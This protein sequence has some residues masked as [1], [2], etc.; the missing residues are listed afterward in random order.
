MYSHQRHHYHQQQ[1]N[2]YGGSGLAAFAHRRSPVPPALS[3]NEGG[4]SERRMVMVP[5]QRSRSLL[6]TLTSNSSDLA[7]PLKGF[8][9]TSPRS[10]VFGSPT[11]K[12]TKSFSSPCALTIPK[13]TQPA[14]PATA[15]PTA[16]PKW[17]CPNKEC[18][19]TDI[20]LVSPND[21]GGTSCDMCGV[22][23]QANQM[24]DGVRQKNCDSNDDK[25]RVADNVAMSSA[26]RSF[27]AMASGDETPS[28]RRK[29]LLYATSN[30][31]GVSRA[32]AQKLAIGKAVSCVESDV[33]AAQRS[34]VEGDSVVVSKRNR[35]LRFTVVQLQTAC[36]AL[37]TRIQRHIRIEAARVVHLGCA[38]AAH[39]T[40]CAACEI[41]IPSRSNALLGLCVVQKCL[42]RLLR[43]SE[44]T[45]DDPNSLDQVAPGESR[46]AVLKALTEVRQDSTRYG[47]G[48]SQRAQTASIVGMILDWAPGQEVVSCGS[49]SSR[50]S[51][52][53]GT[54]SPL[55]LQLDTASVGSPSDVSAPSTPC[56]TSSSSCVTDQDEVLFN[57]RNVVLGAARVASVRTDVR[58]A[59][60][61]AIQTDATM[62]WARTESGLPTCLLGVAVLRA[63]ASKLN[64]DD[65]TEQL[66]VTYSNEYDVSPTTV[67][68]AANHLAGLLRAEP[69]TTTGRAVFGDGIF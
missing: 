31:A 49:P 65:A 33:L 55:Q 41:N 6:E 36:A 57:L 30:G 15:A 2:A 4:G 3:V 8:G 67:R 54:P 34:E 56:T 58:Q 44:H 7:D 35:V 69:E 26:Q 21:E 17:R 27:E 46:H 40:K 23:V 29:R 24:I 9:L 38:H 61:A 5:L 11:V 59:A 16:A 45:E 20:R 32:V 63:V 51:S 22:V 14:P 18:K 62:A 19:N 50:A 52:R 64:V 10:V 47:S 66:L 25:T 39:C 42:E 53:T 28:E 12:I 13:T 37:D 68:D 1:P 60:L 48:A 43:T